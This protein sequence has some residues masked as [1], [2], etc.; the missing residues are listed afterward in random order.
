MEVYNKKYEI[1]EHFQIAE[2]SMV[3]TTRFF[4]FFEISILIDAQHTVIMVVVVFIGFSLTMSHKLQ[5]L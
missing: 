4:Y 5:I 3:Q 2:F 1:C